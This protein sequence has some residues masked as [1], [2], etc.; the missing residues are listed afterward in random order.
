MATKSG[1][2]DFILRDMEPEFWHRVKIRAVTEGETLKAVFSELAEL[3][4]K[5]GLPTIKEKLEK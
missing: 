1:K 5:H 2:V 4:V 3:Y